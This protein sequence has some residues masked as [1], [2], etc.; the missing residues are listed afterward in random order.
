MIKRTTITSIFLVLFLFRPESFMGIP[1]Q[2]A[3][4][5]NFEYRTAGELL[6]VLTDGGNNQ[7][8]IVFR[9]ILSRAE[10]LRP[11]I[12]NALKNQRQ[13]PWAIFMLGFFPHH[14]AR[15]AL[16]NIVAESPLGEERY[17][18]LISLERQLHPEERLA[19]GA[20]MPSP[21]FPPPLPETGYFL[22]LIPTLARYQGMVNTIMGGPVNFAFGIP[23]ILCRSFPFLIA[24]RFRSGRIKSFGRTLVR[25]LDDEDWRIRLAACEKLSPAFCPEAI[26]PLALRLSD[27]EWQVRVRA[28]WV[29]GEW[30]NRRAV[31][32]LIARL[33]MTDY[34]ERKELVKALGKLGGDDAAKAL[35]ERF[36]QDKNMDVKQEALF[37]LESIMKKY[38]DGS[39]LKVI[40]ERERREENEEVLEKIKIVLKRSRKQ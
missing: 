4:P 27:P 13:R 15:R 19:G 25:S 18:A 1:I 35:I 33:K 12:L 14:S 29:L 11:E 40:E 21:P 26:Q 7:N 2:K 16:E 32:H 10:S 36:R 28:A 38:G 17:L 37:C 20:K 9:E 24:S 5:E 31:P 22:R 23:R 39:I 30:R 8:L 6:Q 34:L 3:L